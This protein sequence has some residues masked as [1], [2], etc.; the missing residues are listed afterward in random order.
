MINTLHKVIPGERL[1]VAA[2]ARVS[3]DKDLMEASLNEQIDFY[4]RAIIQNNNWDFA[5]IY[6][7]DGV[8]GTTISKRKGFIKMVNNAKA[9]LIDIILVKSVSRFSRNLINLLDKMEK[10]KDK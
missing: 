7:D 1:K 6:Y 5:G 2:Y 8:S 10:D 4:T 3:S 9:G